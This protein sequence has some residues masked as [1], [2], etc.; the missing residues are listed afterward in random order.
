MTTPTD[1]NYPYCVTITKPG[2]DT[3]RLGFGYQFQA[4]M[5]ATHLR[6]ALRHTGHPEGTTTIDSGPTPPGVYP[7]PP[8]DTTTHVLAEKIQNTPDDDSHFPDLYAR[9]T[10]Q[11]G[12]E[13]AKRVWLAACALLDEP[14]E[15][16]G[17]TGSVTAG[18]DPDRDEWHV[19]V[20]TPGH[21]VEIIRIVAPQV[22]DQDTA[23]ALAEQT[24]EHRGLPHMAENRGLYRAADLVEMCRAAAGIPGEDDATLLAEITRLCDV[25]AR[26]VDSGWAVTDPARIIFELRDGSTK[27]A[28]AGIDVAAIPPGQVGVGS[29][30]A[31]TYTPAEARVIGVAFIAAALRAEKLRAET[32][33]PGPTVGLDP[34]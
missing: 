10:A 17:D 33:G 26:A 34:R 3:V 24:A 28:A 12:P 13:Q 8:L 27:Y 6:T 19:E 25:D 23:R 7:E 29:V 30:E 4:E 16:A 5:A 2:H 32:A 9:L 31:R 18:Y 21:D 14:R 11:K 1:P 22:P 20:R 15:E